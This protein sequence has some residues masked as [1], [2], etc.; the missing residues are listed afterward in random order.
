V[1]ILHERGKLLPHFVH[2]FQG[3]ELGEE[4]KY[5]KINVLHWLKKLGLMKWRVQM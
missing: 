1:L 2:D 4:A 5:C 3:F